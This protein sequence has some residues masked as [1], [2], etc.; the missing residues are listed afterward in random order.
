MELQNYLYLIINL[1][2]FSAPLIANIV[3]KSKELKRF[4][5][6][7]FKTFLIVGIPFI[8]WDSLV[9]SRGDWSFNPDYTLGIKIG[10]IPF[11]EA[12]FFFTIP[13]ASLALY[14]L[15]LL[16]RKD[17][18]LNSKTINKLLYPV[19]LVL[20][21][22]AFFTKDLVYST[23]IFILTAVLVIFITFNKQK[24][25]FYTKNFWIFIIISFVP[26]FIVNTILTAVPIVSYSSSAIINLRIGTIPIEDFFY[27]FLMLGSY[28]LTYYILKHQDE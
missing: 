16:L 18:K 23:N 27:S 5:I 21:L 8:V 14:E 24:N 4:F 13:F 7:F 20:L 12:M 17:S 28:L 9:T 6:N 15:V 2:V 26:F 25:I 11:E 1:T 19:I 3:F 10:N 22:L